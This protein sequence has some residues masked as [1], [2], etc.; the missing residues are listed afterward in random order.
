MR[1]QGDGKA[2]G[3][4]V[5]WGDV[6]DA[7]LSCRSRTVPTVSHVTCVEQ[8]PAISS[9]DACVAINWL[10]D[11]SY[12]HGSHSL[13]DQAGCDHV[14]LGSGLWSNLGKKGL[15]PLWFDTLSGCQAVLVA[16][17]SPS[18]KVSLG[19]KQKWE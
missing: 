7:M 19:V 1:N 12:H 14:E 9:R 2:K 8:M 5:F 13:S 4:A 15:L 10:A 6:A 18:G 16:S 17:L 11:V 3:T